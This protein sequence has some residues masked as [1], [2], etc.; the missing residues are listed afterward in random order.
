MM[1]SIRTKHTGDRTLPVFNKKDASKFV[2]MLEN[3]SSEFLKHHNRHDS[4]IKRI[5][6]M[7]LILEAVN[8]EKMKAFDEKERDDEARFNSMFSDEGETE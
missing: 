4:R 8:E 6:F 3:Y 7:L 1:K 2:A 5:Y